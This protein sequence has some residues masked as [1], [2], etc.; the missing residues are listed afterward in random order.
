MPKILGW[1]EVAH[2]ILVTAQT[3]MCLDRVLVKENQ[4]EGETETII[5]IIEVFIFSVMGCI[6]STIVHWHRKVIYLF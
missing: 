6:Q 4:K 2:A 1:W 5:I 3:S